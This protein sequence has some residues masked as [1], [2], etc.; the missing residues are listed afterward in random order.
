MMIYID[1]QKDVVVIRVV[2]IE[3]GDEHIGN[4]DIDERLGDI[5]HDQA[6]LDA[7]EVGRP[8]C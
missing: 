8:N 2:L 5:L 6:I 7:E 1:L 3:E 4:V